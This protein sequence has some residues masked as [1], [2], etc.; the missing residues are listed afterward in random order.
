MDTLEI[1]SMDSSRLERLSCTRGAR[2]FSLFDMCM[3]VS[4]CVCMQCDCY[5]PSPDCA[6]MP[7][8]TE[9]GLRAA[10]GSGVRGL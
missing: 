1:L 8:T 2:A 5:H 10:P 4:E 7:V 3:R 9:S 6:R